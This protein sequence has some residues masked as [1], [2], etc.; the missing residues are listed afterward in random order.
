MWAG[1]AIHFRTAV[2]LAAAVA[3]A[4]AC[5][6][7]LPWRHH[8]DLAAGRIAAAVV[9]TLATGVLLT[10]C[11]VAVRP[12]LALRL[13]LGLSLTVA[14]AVLAAPVTLR[15][16]RG[17]RRGRGFASLRRRGGRLGRLE[18]RAAL[19]AVVRAAHHVAPFGVAELRTLV[20]VLAAAVSRAAVPAPAA[21]SAFVLGQGGARRPR[22]QHQRQHGCARS[23]HLSSW[24]FVA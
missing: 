20:A 9:L 2:G 13:T 22:Q 8:D 12:N 19:A 10:P 18:F 11:D 16:L 7:L 3:L 24:P 14:A 1:S 6:V 4:A 15:R 17:D 21:V 23:L 5:A